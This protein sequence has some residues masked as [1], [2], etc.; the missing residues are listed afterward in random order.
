MLAES[1]TAQLAFL[2]TEPGLK[3]AKLGIDGIG[4]QI[5]V[6]IP[7]ESPLPRNENPS[8]AK[9]GV[10]GSTRKEEKDDLHV[11]AGDCVSSEVIG[12]PLPTLMS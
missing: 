11:N 3:N 5:S 2:T 9:Q 1:S 4:E 10:D 7:M 12:D 8:D 6:P